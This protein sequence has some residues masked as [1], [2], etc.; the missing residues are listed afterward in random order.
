MNLDAWRHYLRARI[1][2]ALR[3]PRPAIAAF[4]DA[5]AADPRF[6]RAVHGLAYMLAGERAW[7]EA[8]EAFAAV[9]QLVPENTR[10]WY[11]FGYV[12]DQLG[13]HSEAAAAFERATKQDPKLDLAWFGLG[14]MRT[15]LGQERAA[16]EAFERAAELQPMNGAVWYELGMAWH[17]AHEPDRVRAVVD[18]LNRYQRHHAHK[19][20]VDAGRSD[21][22]HI[23]ADLRT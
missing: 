2:R 4:R 21:L 6:A 3:R 1:H 22:A 11:N 18:H 16:V 14:R 7:A 15:A 20:I 13:H 12:C 8:H 19:L 23:V 17:R 9:L 5:R 10:A